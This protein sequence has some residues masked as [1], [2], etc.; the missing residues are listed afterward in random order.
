MTEYRGKLIKNIYYMLSYAFQVLRQE[1]YEEIVGE[2]FDEVEDLFAAILVKGVS[3]QLKQ[4]LYRE[5]I[6][7]SDNLNVIRG[8]L[9]MNRQIQNIMMKNSKVSCIFDEL[10]IDNF[11]NQ[12]LKTAMYYLVKARGVQNERKSD[13]KKLLV[14]FC[15]VRLLEP[16]EIHWNQLYFQR[17]NQNY[18]MLLNI[19]YF[20]LSGMLQTTDDGSYRMASFT[21]EH[22][23]KLYEKFILEY[24]LRHYPELEARSSQIA[25]NL[26]ADTPMIKFLPSMQTDITLRNKKNGKTLIIDAKFYSHTMQVQFDKPTL[27]S[28]NM[29]QIFAYVKNEDKNASGN[30]SGI[31]LYGKTE[32]QITPD[33][34]YS[35]S[36]NRIGAKTLDLNQ[37]FK[38]IARQ[39]N[40]LAD[41][42][43]S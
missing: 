42:Y 28:N 15:D 8:K 2:E 21:D 5:Y 20:I 3:R 29:Y 33:C 7:L 36:G 10:S 43:V 11:Y 6:P 31:L 24:Y 9:D 19:C 12:I 4:G 32:E 26:D 37:D 25:W 23:A 13:L 17:N 18:E 16:A 22:M 30:V 40:C 38:E 34:M 35:I 1:N 41:E 39:L 14:F 27:H